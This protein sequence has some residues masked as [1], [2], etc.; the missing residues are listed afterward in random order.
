[1]LIEKLL[2]YVKAHTSNVFSIETYFDRLLC[3]L[4]RML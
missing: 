3:H 4:L 1:M 2:V